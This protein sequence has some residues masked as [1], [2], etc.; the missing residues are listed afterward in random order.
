MLASLSVT[1]SYQSSLLWA[2]LRWR[3]SPLSEETQTHEGQIETV[4]HIE[5]AESHTRRLREESPRETKWGKVRGQS[6]GSPTSSPAVSM[7]LQAQY[8]PNMHEEQPLCNLL[9]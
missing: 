1:W 3:R 6:K 9:V 7:D 2:D 4:A 5:G 8:F